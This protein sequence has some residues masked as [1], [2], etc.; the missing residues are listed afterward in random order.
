MSNV[1]LLSCPN[2]PMAA[3]GAGGRSCNPLGAGPWLCTSGSIPGAWCR[4]RISS[5][6][7]R[8]RTLLGF[9]LTGEGKRGNPERFP[10]PRCATVTPSFPRS[11]PCSWAWWGGTLHLRTDAGCSAGWASAAAARPERCPLAPGSLPETR[12]PGALTELRRPSASR[13]VHGASGPASPAAAPPRKW[14]PAAGPERSF[15]PR[16]RPEGGQ[17]SSG[18]PGLREAVGRG[19]SAPR[20]HRSKAGWDRAAGS[21]SRP[22]AP[23]AGLADPGPVQC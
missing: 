14:T 22:W 2:R 12:G 10:S 3:G 16:C 9:A 5:R 15:P 11:P 18:R 1:W 8:V 6:S 13:G 17:T 7:G 19:A 21:Q 23:G 20:C 4:T